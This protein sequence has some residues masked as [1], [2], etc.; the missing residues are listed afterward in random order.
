MISDKRF[1]RQVRLLHSSDYN[2]VFKETRCKSSDK[3][4]TLLACPN[5]KTFPRLGLA[6]SKKQLKSAVVR[7]RVKRIIRESFRHHKIGLGSLDIVVLG[8]NAA[9]VD[10][11]I[12][13]RSLQRHWE[14]LAKKCKD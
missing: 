9:D 4:L 3:Y 10:K 13:S 2:K 5:D 8:R 12:L 11:K 6:I 7:H 14:V 1:P